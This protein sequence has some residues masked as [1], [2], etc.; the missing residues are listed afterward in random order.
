MWAAAAPAFPADEGLCL[1]G[2]DGE[3]SHEQMMCHFTH[4]QYVGSANSY[5]LRCK[6][7][8]VCRCDAGHRE[9]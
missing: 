1:S 2:R 9:P 8:S 3:D 7:W 5:C 6:C 4:L